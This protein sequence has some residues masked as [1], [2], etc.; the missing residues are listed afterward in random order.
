MRVERHRHGVDLRLASDNNERTYLLWT[1]SEHSKPEF[2]LRLPIG[3]NRV[4]CWYVRYRPKAYRW[5][6]C[7]GYPVDN[8]TRAWICDPL[9]LYTE[10]ELVAPD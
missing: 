1:W 8:P 6:G 4:L 5:T 3:W 2:A 9:K 10:Q 7:S